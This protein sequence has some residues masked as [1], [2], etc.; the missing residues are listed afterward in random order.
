MDHPEL[1]KRSTSESDHGNS[2][3]GKKKKT[4]IDGVIAKTEELVSVYKYISY[5]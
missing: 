1:N 2:P 5:L 3:P 4:D